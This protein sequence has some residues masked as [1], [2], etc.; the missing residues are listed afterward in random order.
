MKRN[1]SGAARGHGAIRRNLRILAVAFVI[2]LAAV[3][4]IHN[5]SASPTQNDID[6]VQTLLPAELREY[7]V[8]DCVEF[9]CQFQVAKLVQSIFLRRA[10][11]DSGIALDHPREI[12]DVLRVGHGLCFDRA[13]AIEQ[14]LRV[15][16]FRTRRVYFFARR[17]GETG[18]SDL[19]SRQVVSHTMLEV[20]TSRGWMLVDSNRS[21]IGVAKN[22]TLATARNL[23]QL[24]KDRLILPPTY[25]TALNYRYVYGLLSRHGHHYPPYDFIPDFSISDAWSGLL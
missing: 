19:A 10:P 20:S 5:V 17:T 12:R 24:E 3:V 6:A 2:L 16:G 22:G 21:W 13:R 8:K 14:T 9:S 18:V 11:I 15:L 4:E 23:L 25:L 7:A 1:G